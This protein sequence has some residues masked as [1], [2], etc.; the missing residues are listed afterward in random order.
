MVGVDVIQQTGNEIWNKRYCGVVTDL[1]E[2]PWPAVIY[3]AV[4]VDEKDECDDKTEERPVKIQIEGDPHR[5]LSQS[6]I[7][8]LIRRLLELGCETQSN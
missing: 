4:D 7:D 1:T 3:C 2:L 5:K 6:E 8:E